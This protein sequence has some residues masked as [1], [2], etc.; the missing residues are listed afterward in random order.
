MVLLIKYYPT[1]MHF[2]IQ[3]IDPIYVDSNDA[4]PNSHIHQQCASVSVFISARCHA[5]HSHSHLHTFRPSL[6]PEPPLRV[7]F[8]DPKL[9]GDPHMAYPHSRGCCP[10]VAHVYSANPTTRRRLCQTLPHHASVRTT[11]AS[12]TKR[13]N[14]TS[15]YR[16]PKT[17]RPT[18]AHS[19]SRIAECANVV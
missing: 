6:T 12:V 8:P 2:E 18:R 11:H 14:M 7:L 10:V 4:S 17:T 15:T 1:I 3:R 5:I 13:L 19:D 16:L 9:G